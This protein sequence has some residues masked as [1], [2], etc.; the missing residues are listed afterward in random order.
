MAKRSLAHIIRDVIIVGLIIFAG[1]YFDKGEGKLW[2]LKKLWET[3]V[4]RGEYVKFIR[5]TSSDKKDLF[6]AEINGIK[7][8]NKD[9]KLLFS[10]DYSRECDYIK[11]G[12][13]DVD[14]DG[15]NEI[16]VV[17]FSRARKTL[18]FEILRGNGAFIKRETFGE[19]SPF[20]MKPFRVFFFSD[21]TGYKVL[22]GGYNGEIELFPNFYRKS[23]IGNRFQGGNAF[24]ENPFSVNNITIASIDG[25]KRIVASIEGGFLFYMDLSGNV[26][27]KIKVFSRGNSKKILRK[28]RCYDVDFDGDDEVL[29]GNDKKI[30]PTIL[31]ID[32]RGD[33]LMIDYRKY[34]WKTKI[35]EI[36]SFDID[37]NPDNVEVFYGTKKSVIKELKFN[38]KSPGVLSKPDVKTFH[39]TGKIVELA[40]IFDVNLGKNF[41]LF[42]SSYGDI[43][44]VC[45]GR[46]KFVSLKGGI[47]HRL[48][49]NKNV[50]AALLTNK[51]YLFKSR[52]STRPFYYSF[53]FGAIL[54]AIFYLILS[55]VIGRIRKPKATFTV[56]EETPEAL[57]AERKMLL[58]SLFDLKKVFDAGEM[59][60]DAYAERTKEIRERIKV[61][62]EKLFEM[63]VKLEVEIYKCPNC[64]ASV[65]IHEDRCPYCGSPLN[66]G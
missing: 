23:I 66:L 60:G 46:A 59:D 33:S 9:G 50:F 27:D 32:I 44:V 39:A 53:V 14:G 19:D 64:G 25:K 41:L 8:F 15:K 38:K 58:D 11:T 16:L 10:K 3:N 55:S 13:S 65:S 12:L 63:G 1:F 6:V 30:D 21:D 20:Y 51:L 42:G 31:V 26:I 45:D 56:R 17:G 2:K 47:L 62:E 40:K 54:L 43:G 18:F 52:F 48:D 49:T 34:W 61:I 7:V 57:K 5:L 36:R 37:G 35:T 28:M 22:I 29:I 4:N 24:L